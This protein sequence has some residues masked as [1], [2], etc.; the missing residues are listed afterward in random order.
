MRR[1]EEL[2][3][4]YANK[5]L[6]FFT[7]YSGGHSLEAIEAKMKE[8]SLTLPVATDGYYSTRFVAPSLCVVWV[9]GVDGKVVH[10]GQEGWEDAAL[11]ELKKA[12]YP[13]LGMD[14]IAAPLESAAKAFGEGNLALADKLAEAV[15]DGDFEDSVLDQAQALRKRVGERRKLLES[16][17]DTEEVCGDLDLA[18]AC[19]KELGARLGENE[20]E[21]SPKEE[22]AR[23]GKL[24][25][26][27]KERK[28]R[29]A[30]IDARQKC[31][32]C[33]ER[34]GNSKPKTV[35]ACDKATALMKEYLAANK[36]RRPVGSAQEL[37]D[38]WAAWKE[39][40]E[41]RKEDK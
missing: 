20:Y 27:D 40:L 41:P 31:W 16:R 25:D 30:F 17:A 18:L 3:K 1:W 8:L 29:R 11:K 22:A 33:F 21:R 28:A 19:W 23:I 5:G 34:V 24:A 4:E 26:L 7:A 2:N 35:A 32:A 9:I 12:K 14:K 37:I 15:S 6:R 39:E 13:G 36:D 38:Y 10:V